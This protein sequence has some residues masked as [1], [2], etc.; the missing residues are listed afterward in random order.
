M[1]KA[2]SLI[3]ALSLLLALGTAALAEP[4]YTPGTYSATVKG[5]SGDVV[6]EVTFDEGSITSVNVVAQTETTDAIAPCALT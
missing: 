3:L 5:A 6:V 1:K 2:L 4:V